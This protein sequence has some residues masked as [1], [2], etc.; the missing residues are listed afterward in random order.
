M[1]EKIEL[2]RE[3]APQPQK[4]G[5]SRTIVKPKVLSEEKTQMKNHTIKSNE[6]SINRAPI[7]VCRNSLGFGLL[8]AYMLM[9]WTASSVNGDTV[10]I[11]GTNDTDCSMI[12]G[13]DLYPWGPY[14]GHE[15]WGGRNFSNVYEP[16][17]GLT[18]TAHTLLRFHLP[19]LESVHVISA[20]ITF[21]RDS[22]LSFEGTVSIYRLLESWAEG[23]GS[24]SLTTY[25]TETGGTGGTGY[26]P[27]VGMVDWFDRQHG[28]ATW[29]TP[30]AVGPGSSLTLPTDV[31]TV[32]GEYT[33]PLDVTADVQYWYDHGLDITNFGWVLT[34]IDTDGQWRVGLRLLS[35][36]SS[37]GPVFTMEYVLEPNPV[38]VLIDIK[39]GSDP[40]PINPGSNG[41]IPVAIFSS[42]ELDATTID[43]TTV[44]L[45]GATVAVRGKGNSLAHEEDV[46]GDGLLDLVVQVE[47]T[48]FDE[49]GEDGVVIL[50]AETTDGTQITGSDVVVIV[51][52]GE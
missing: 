52:P 32:Q 8:L 10:S 42:P 49:I 4:I 38:E 25:A 37:S 34:S 23:T 33:F 24:G 47:T 44:E 35:D 28:V 7:A 48:G 36:D 5:Y 17:G 16:E 46:D 9:T 27:Q 30:G 15:N 13:A 6:H 43:P 14:T 45:G 22:Y 18:A 1:D 29:S 12:L 39:P 2:P 19:E 21:R 51:P 31:H 3:A 50:T 40:N 20:T 41:L 11:T 26:G